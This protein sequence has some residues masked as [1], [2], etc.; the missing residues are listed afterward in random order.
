MGLDLYQCRPESTLPQSG[1]TT[2]SLTMHSQEM[3]MIIKPHPVRWVSS[4]N[5]YSNL[6]GFI[7]PTGTRR[8]LRQPQHHGSCHSGELCAG[9]VPCGHKAVAQYRPGLL[10]PPRGMCPVGA[11]FRR[12]P[13]DQPSIDW[14]GS[15]PFRSTPSR[16][17]DVTFKPQSALRGHWEDFPYAPE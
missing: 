6:L 2:V 15:G 1:S 9:S 7:W 16:N 12:T 3:D 14:G 5:S 17:I 11:P 10:W 13:I 8:R 4:R